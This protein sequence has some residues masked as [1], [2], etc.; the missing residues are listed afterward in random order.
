MWRAMMRCDVIGAKAS[1][2]ARRCNLQSVVVLLAQASAAM[3]Q[4]VENAKT[5]SGQGCAVDPCGIRHDC[6]ALLAW[7]SGIADRV[8]AGFG[9]RPGFSRNA[10]SRNDEAPQ[11]KP[12]AGS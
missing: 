3:I 7:T 4:M 8:D 1:R 10:A 5:E 2:I 9:S 12:L 11:S 6:N